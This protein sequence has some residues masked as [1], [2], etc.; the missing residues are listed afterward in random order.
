MSNIP[1]PKT[2]SKVKWMQPPVPTK[3]QKQEALKRLEKA[4]SLI[5]KEDAWC[6]G[7]YAKN[8]KGN[9]VP[10][11]DKSAVCFCAFGSMIHV[12]P[13]KEDVENIWPAAYD[14]MILALKEIVEDDNEPSIMVYNDRHTHKEVVGL[15]KKAK[16]I[17]KKELK[18]A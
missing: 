10:P 5:A 6:V 13:S 18:N 11:T 9:V 14:W 16:D 12:M 4:S 3:A 2:K 7:H 15:F 1:T 17:A 8:A